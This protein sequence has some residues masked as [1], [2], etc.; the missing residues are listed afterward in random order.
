M[1]GTREPAVFGGDWSLEKTSVDPKDSQFIDVLRWECEQ[2]AR[3]YLVPPQMIYAATSGQSV[4]Y[5]NASQTDLAF[6]KWSLRWP[7][8]RLQWAWSA[9]LPQP[10]VVRFNVDALL[11]VTAMER[12]QV[13]EIRLRT[14]TRTVNEVRRIEDEPPFDDAAFDEPGVPADNYEPPSSVGDDGLPTDGGAADV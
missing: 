11:E 2:A 8:R 4:T 12:A 13:H 3:I 6:L 1:R 5:A 9:M 7:L 10:W 14:K